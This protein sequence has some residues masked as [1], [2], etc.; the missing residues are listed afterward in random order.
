MAAIVPISLTMIS[1]NAYVSWDKSA[2]TSNNIIFH[3][4]IDT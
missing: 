1:D 2:N 3:K 4:I